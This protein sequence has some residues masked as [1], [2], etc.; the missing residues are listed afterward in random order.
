MTIPNYITLFRILLVPVFFTALVSYETGQEWLRWT[1]FACFLT[2]SLTDAVDGL[3]ARVMQKYSELGRFLDPLADKLLLLSGF[4]GLLFVQGFPYTP[5]LWVT[6]TIVFRDMV[7]VIGI[8]VIF[9]VS[10]KLQIQP[11]FLGKVTTAFQMGTLVA[12]LLF[13]PIAIPLW[14]VTVAL[15]IVSCLSYVVREMK[16]L[17]SH[18]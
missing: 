3:A 1:A 12:I 16:L 8:V 4:L 7:I 10:G 6:V 5:P 18:A 9:F 13:W 11:N 17:N 2:A 15:T 14:Y